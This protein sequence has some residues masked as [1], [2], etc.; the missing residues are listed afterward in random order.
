MG[1][2]HTKILDSR[3]L[4]VPL[5]PRKLHDIHQW[6]LE[7]EGDNIVYLIHTDKFA[8]GFICREAGTWLRTRTEKEKRDMNFKPKRKAGKGSK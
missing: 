4:F 1:W 8:I 3:S 5:F 6:F 2:Q 7:R